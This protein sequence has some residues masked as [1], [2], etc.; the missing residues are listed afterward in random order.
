MILNIHFSAVMPY[1]HLVM[2]MDC[3]LLTQD[4]LQTNLES[5]QERKLKEE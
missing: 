3:L 1:K 4:H 5:E 2:G